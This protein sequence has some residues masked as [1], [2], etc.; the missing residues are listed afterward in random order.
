VESLDLAVGVLGGLFDGAGGLG[1]ED[2]AGGTDGFGAS[3][4]GALGRLDGRGHGA[5]EHEAGRET[6]RE[7]RGG[8]SERHDGGCV[9]ESVRVGECGVEMREREREREIGYVKE[10]S[11]S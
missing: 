2:G 9:C 10:R 5:A 3:G 7:A 11:K 8:H 6:G 1:R 4:N